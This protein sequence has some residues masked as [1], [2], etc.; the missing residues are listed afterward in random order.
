MKKKIVFLSLIIMMLVTEL[1]ILTGCKSKKGGES[2][3]PVDETLV[4]VNGVDLHF[5]KEAS[6]KKLKYTIAGDLREEKYPRYIQYSMYQED[7]TTLLFFRIFYYEGRDNNFAIKDLGIGGDVT[8][9]D[10]K[11]DNIEYKFYPYS[12]NDGGTMHLYFVNKDGNTYVL[13]FV[14]KYDIKDFEERVLNSVKF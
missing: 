12:Q 3:Q 6:F 11:T 2:A 8:L 4:K 1:F 14:S 10:G 7:Q 13:N 9:T 5:T